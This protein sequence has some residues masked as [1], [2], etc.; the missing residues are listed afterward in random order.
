MKFAGIELYNAAWADEFEYEPVV[1]AQMR[2]VTGALIHFEQAQPTGQSMTLTDSWI[3]RSV[4]L[5]L[6]ALRLQ[7]N[8]QHEVE[9]D[10]GRKFSVIFDRSKTPSLRAELIEGTPALP[11]N[12]DIYSVTLT[13]QIISE[14]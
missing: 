5:E 2:S 7:S 9:L 13:L 4:L 11:T 1:Q 14:L 12:D 6:Q 3:K 10:D 8:Q